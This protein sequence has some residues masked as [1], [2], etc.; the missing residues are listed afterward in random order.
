M[1]RESLWYSQESNLAF[2]VFSWALSLES[3]STVKVDLEG[4]EPSL[5]ALQGRRSFC[6]RYRPKIR[7]PAC[8]AS[9]RLT[10]PQGLRK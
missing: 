7:V 10:L 4:F 9:T 1:H 8:V 3:V 5:F 6:C 2:P